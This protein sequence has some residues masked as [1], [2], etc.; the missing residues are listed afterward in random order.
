MGELEI[1]AVICWDLKNNSM[2]TGEVVVGITSIITA[3]NR[4]HKT[5]KV[6]KTYVNFMASKNIV[7]ISQFKMESI[8]KN[9]YNRHVKKIC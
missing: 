9:I 6:L 8:G 1:A 3:K 2:K 5:R 4:N 7:N